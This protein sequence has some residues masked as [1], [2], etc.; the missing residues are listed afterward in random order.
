MA[1]HR[2]EMVSY[3]READIAMGILSNQLGAGRAAMS[4]ELASDV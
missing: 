2:E 3:E 4:E 1:G